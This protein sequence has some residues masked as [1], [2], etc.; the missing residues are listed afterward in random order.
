M[1]YMLV[2]Y[3][4]SFMLFCLDFGLVTAILA[5]THSCL[6]QK[7][8]WLFSQPVNVPLGWNSLIILL[9]IKYSDIYLKSTCLNVFF[10]SDQMI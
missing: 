2:R 6:T 10:K 3:F 1:L 9:L 7:L 8:Y 5:T 4:P